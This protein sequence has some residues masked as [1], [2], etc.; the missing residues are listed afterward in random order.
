MIYDGPLVDAHHHFWDLSMGKHPW[1]QAAR[2]QEM[3]FGDPGPLLRNY[4]PDDLRAD[5]ARQNLVASV[6]VE[7]AWDPTDPVGETRWLDGIAERSGLPTVLV[8]QAPLDKADA[9]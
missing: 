7:A 9:Q 6:H 1:L 3:V 5:A 2:K 4:L 8:V